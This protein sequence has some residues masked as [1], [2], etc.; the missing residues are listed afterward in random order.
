MEIKKTIIEG[1]R[2]AAA[3]RGYELTPQW[4][5]ESQPLARHLQRVFAHHR[6]DCVLDVGANKGQYRDFLREEV[7]FSGRIISFEPVRRYV[8]LLEKRTADD[9]DWEVMAHALGRE[10]AT[11]EINVTT[12]PGLNSFLEPRRDAVEGFWDEETIVKESVIVRR[13]DDVYA[14]L[15]ERFGFRKPYVKLDTQG[16]DLEV[17]AGGVQSLSNACG[18]QTEASIKPIYA[19]MPNYRQT[20]EAMEALGFQLSGMFPVTHDDGLRLIEFDCVMVR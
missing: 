11:A 10:E 7:G 19:S 17:V 6:V 1:I 12:S 5:I 13:L 9:A 14:S 8:E 4:K 20:I 15:R 2:H 16:F 18:L 3:S